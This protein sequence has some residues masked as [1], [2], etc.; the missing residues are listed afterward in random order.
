MIQIRP[1]HQLLI[2]AFFLGLSTAAQ[3]PVRLF[4]PYAADSAAL[5][6]DTP[7]T[8]MPVAGDVQLKGDPRV[9]ELMAAYPDMQHVVEGYRVQIFL[10]DKTDAMRTRAQFMQ[11]HPDMPAYLSYLAPNFRVRV[12]DLPDRLSA[13][14]LRQEL[15]GDFPGCYVVPDQ[16]MPAHPPLDR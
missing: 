14:R 4:R 1:V 8:R 16:V 15:R 2:G 10:G 7:R 3:P 6:P 5:R 11:Q 9:L 13:E 12:G